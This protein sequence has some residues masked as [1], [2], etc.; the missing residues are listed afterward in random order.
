MPL[1]SGGEKA[2]LALA[3]LSMNQDNFLILDEPT[4][5]L[6]IDS[7]EVLENALIE[8]DGTI[9]FVSHDR[10][11]INR[12][13]TKVV[14]LTP[15]G[16]TMYLGDYDYFVEKKKETALLEELTKQETTK[17]DVPTVSNKS[18]FQ[19]SKDFQRQLRQLSRRIEAIEN[20]LQEIEQEIEQLQLNMTEPT[21]LN[22]HV[23]LIELDQKVSQLETEQLTLMEEWEEKSLEIGRAHV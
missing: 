7:K 17:Q 22:D 4:N 12:I 5:H 3:K 23:A 14:E 1:L 20:R 16:S 10:Y 8:F 21:V 19:Q 11:F 2:R 6:D 15:E 13:A 18:D 9:L